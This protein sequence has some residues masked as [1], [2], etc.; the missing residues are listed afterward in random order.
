MAK[1]LNG[2]SFD[3]VNLFSQEFRSLLNSMAQA[4]GKIENIEIGPNLLSEA[5]PSHIFIDG[6]PHEEDPP[7]IFPALITDSND[8]GLYAWR[9]QTSPS[10]T[11]REGTL[12]QDPAE[13]LQGRI[14]YRSHVGAMVLMTIREGFHVLPEDTFGGR[15]VFAVPSELFAVDVEQDGGEDGTAGKPASWTYTV[16]L[17]G[18]VLAQGVP[19]MKPRPNGKMLAAQPIGNE[20]GAPSRGLALWQHSLNEEDEIN[21]HLW[22]VTEVPDTYDCDSSS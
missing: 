20:S 6:I 15:P 16:M 19:V 2:S 12:E 1:D 14:H 21:I 9:E 7:Q 22:D 13:E 4:C 10:R 3:N 17:G 5:T 8:E 11:P 18:K